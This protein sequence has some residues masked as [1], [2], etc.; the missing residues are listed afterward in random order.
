MFLIYIYI[1]IYKKFS[2]TSPSGGPQ[3]LY[4]IVGV[5]FYFYLDNLRKVRA[6][7]GHFLH[8]VDLSIG[9]IISIREPLQLKILKEN[10]PQSSTEHV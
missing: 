1:Y 4:L 5:S 10:T 9:K 8:H 3:G 7:I 6:N 2:Q